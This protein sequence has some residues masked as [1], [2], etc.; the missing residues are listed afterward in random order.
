MSRPVNA[1]SGTPAVREAAS[2][3]RTPPAPAGPAG[4][5]AGPAAPATH[6][7][8]PA[9]VLI[10]DAQQRIVHVEGGAFESHGL[11]TRGWI[12]LSIDQVLPAE[13]HATLIP[14]Y[15]AA[16]A[17]ESQSFEYWTQ[18]GQ[19]AYWVQMAPV[20]NRDGEVTSVVAVMEDI[21]QRLR[22][23]AEL[24]RSEARLREAE[25]MV[26]VGSW[27]VEV[28]TGEITF[29]A[30]LARLLGLDDAGRLD[31]Q[32]HLELVHPEDRELVAGLG[33]ACVPAGSVGTPQAPGRVSV[34][35]LEPLLAA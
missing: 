27:E 29:S 22:M 20:R 16:I 26:G 1:R 31:P 18:D 23:T 35:E 30:G 7:V 9:A 19:G 28:L 10:A 13:A 12:G 5:A 32:S 11:R 3:A 4:A 8:A 24:A 6:A 17:G 21:T 14:R 15:R 25:R 33:A 34:N 2:L